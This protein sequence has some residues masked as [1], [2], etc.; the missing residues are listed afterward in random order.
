MEG[1]VLNPGGHY[2]SIMTGYGGLPE[3]VAAPIWNKV[4][5]WTGYGPR[6]SRV[7]VAPCGRDMMRLTALLE[8]GEIRPIVD[9]MWPMM[10]AVEA[11]EY[12]EKRTC[13]REGDP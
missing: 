7:S 13:S 6:W 5:Q 4:K 3:L 9:R 1:G 10:R 12:L 8:S 2:L 11:H